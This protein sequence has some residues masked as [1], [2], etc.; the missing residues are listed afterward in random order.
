MERNFICF[1]LFCVVNP[2]IVTIVFCLDFLLLS[3]SWFSSAPFAVKRPFIPPPP[4]LSAFHFAFFRTTP[5]WDTHR[6]TTPVPTKLRSYKWS[7]SCL[8]RSPSS[9]Y[10]YLQ[11][12]MQLFIS[13]TVPDALLNSPQKVFLVVSA[14][15]SKLAKSC[16]HRICTSFNIFVPKI[17]GCGGRGPR[18]STAI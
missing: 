16:F 10:Q 12:Q 7:H 3:C 18:R 13:I 5:G 1:C 2:M 11:P 9:A 6:H 8:H 4:I 15:W 14:M 17:S